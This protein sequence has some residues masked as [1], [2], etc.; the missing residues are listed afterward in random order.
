MDYN[1]LSELL[2]PNIKKT[3]EEIEAMFPPRQLPEGAKVTRFAPSPTGFVHFGSLFPTMVGE[4]LAHQSGGVFYLRIEDTDAKREVEGADMDI[5]N[6]YASYGI[7]FD[8]GIC[9][10]GEKGNYGP[11]RQSK[12]A[13]IYQT[14]AKKLVEEGKAYPCFCTEEELSAIREEQEALKANPGYYGRW[15]KYRDADLE[16]VKE[17]MADGL[18]FVLRFR[19]E[20]NI[21]NKI[22]FTDLIKGAI[23]ITENDID[24]VLLKSDGIPT[25]HFAHAIDDHLMHTTHVVRG[26]EWLPSLPFH[27][28]LFRALGFKIP[29]YLHISQLMKM[30]GGSKKKLSKRDL[31]AGLS[32]YVSEG[33]PAKSVKE[34]VMTLLNSNYEEWRAA[35]PKADMNDFAFSI[36]KMSASGSLFDFDKLNDIS[37]NTIAHMSADEVYDEIVKWA[38]EYDTELY[39]LFTRDS[40]YAK[41]I[42]SIGRG[43]PKPRKD[44]C[45]WKDVKPYVG[46]FYDELFKVEA[47]I[48]AN[49]DKEDVKKALTMFTETYDEKDDANEWFA[50]LKVIAEKLGFA[51]ETKL[52]KKNPDDYKGHVGDISMFIR[53]ALTG[54]TN[55]PD[56]YEV[57]NILGKE[58][59][60]S[61]IN[62]A[63]A[64]I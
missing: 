7:F 59:S 60:L 20:G 1:A 32:Y 13:E 5:I 21:E 53:I 43:T 30:E 8:E 52:Y 63:I 26:E 31:G 35:N 16:T 49:F 10:G 39:D 36:K 6:S 47:E 57:M 42:L 58:R 45:I 40:E 34:Y 55:S 4:R 38:K 50:K 23:E 15:A 11:Y 3:P 54:K 56:M 25:Y 19:S 64:N 2:F 12:R 33:Y 28:Q 14:Y 48:P 37:K 24:H 61:R 62:N 9:A 29:K 41:R 51:P 44:L 22:K 46:L 18:P 17:K 27:V